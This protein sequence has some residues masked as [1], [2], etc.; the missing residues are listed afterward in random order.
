MD[1]A[2]VSNVVYPFVKGGAEKRIHE[3][4]TRLAA[5]GHDVTVYAR[6]FWDGPAV[7]EYE[8]MTLR[9]VSPERELY[10]GDRRSIS[11]AIEFAAHLVGPLRRRADEHDLVVASV[12]PYFPVLSAFAGRALSGTPLVT[13]WHEVWGPYWDEYLGALA[14]F[15]KAVER[16]A[17]SVPQ[18]PV[19]VSR[20]TA[21]RLTD[22][23]PGRESV[24]V[25]PNGIDVERIRS[26]PPAEDGFDVLF[27]G[28]LIADKNVDV[29]LD[30]FD[31]LAG[32]YDCTLGVVGE[33]PE[34]DRLRERAR[35]LRCGDRIT[36]LGFLEEYD[37]V[38]A[39]M[40]AATVFASPSTREGF[41]I[42]FAEAMAADCTVVA[43]SHPDSAA[44]EVIGGGG[45]LTDPEP[46]PVAEA[47]ERALNGERPPEDP[48]TVAEEY[49]WDA[50]ADRAERVYAA[51][52][53]GEA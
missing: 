1:I 37:D 2:F 15:G 35:S 6:R 26:V 46:G 51:V 19:A 7:M 9:A 18:H 12:F 36:F 23:G 17:A 5:A 44:D 49:D 3:I 10:A 4:G 14:P 39:Q 48:E 21:D 16:A 24:D 53:R 42:T 47:L 45:F 27:A 29:L 52:T 8:G 33:G 31:R 13:T 38:L 30:A 43:A 34:L 25:V 20:I 28:R 50:V 40:R 41:G 32:E 22:I 11:E